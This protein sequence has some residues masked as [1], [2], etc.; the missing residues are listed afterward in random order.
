MK[1]KVILILVLS[2]F[3]GQKT[4]AQALDC[5]NFKDGTFYYPTIPNSISV[6]KKSIQKS[7]SNGK[8]TMIWKVKW[9]SDCQYKMVCKKVLVKPYS[10]KKG[11]K[12][13]ATIISTDGSCY[14]TSIIYF[15]KQNPKGIDYPNAEMCVKKD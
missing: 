6:R 10:I 13:I 1:F 12:I 11:D 15:N 5:Q 4:Q 8:L 7:Y 9:I 3:W 14:T 2:I